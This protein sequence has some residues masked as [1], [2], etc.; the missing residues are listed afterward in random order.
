[1]LA[2]S[3]L[4]GFTIEHK[5]TRKDCQTMPAVMHIKDYRRII[6]TNERSEFLNVQNHKTPQGATISIPS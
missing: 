1:M 2:M 6:G 5:A 3:I 4:D